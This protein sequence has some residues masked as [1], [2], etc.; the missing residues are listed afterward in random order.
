MHLYPEQL[1]SKRTPISL[2][3]R[4]PRLNHSVV[5]A[6]IGKMKVDTTV[7]ASKKGKRSKMF[8]QSKAKS[9]I[10]C[11]SPKGSLQCFHSPAWN[12]AGLLKVPSGSLWLEH[13][14]Q[15]EP[16]PSPSMIPIPSAETYI[17]RCATLHLWNV[18]CICGFINKCYLCSLSLNLQTCLLD[19]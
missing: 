10:R 5:E 19:L 3:L 18:L 15:I 13:F 12:T 1:R 16:T 8:P 6:R 9:A 2:F 4:F 11:I 17:K 7:R 14:C